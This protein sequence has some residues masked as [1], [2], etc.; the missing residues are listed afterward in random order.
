MKRLGSVRAAVGGLTVLLLLGGASA[1]ADVHWAVTLSS[2]NA[3]QA[4]ALT[5]AAPTGVAAACASSSTDKVTVTW[6]AASHA[7]S[8]TVFEKKTSASYASAGTTSGTSWASGALTTGKYKFE[9]A[10]S[11]GAN[12]ASGNSSATSPALKITK[13]AKTCS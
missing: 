9:V 10:T 1:G 2:G 12:W 6:T 11:I 13:T 4:Q 7:T 8:Y 3:G 5:P